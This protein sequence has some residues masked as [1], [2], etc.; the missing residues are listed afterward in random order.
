VPPAAHEVIAY[1]DGEAV[2]AGDERTV[3]GRLEQGVA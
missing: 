2:D 1:R 3:R